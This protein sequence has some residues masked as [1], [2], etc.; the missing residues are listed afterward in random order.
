MLKR[1]FTLH[2]LLGYSQQAPSPIKESGGPSN[3][4]PKYV[5]PMNST[6]KTHTASYD[7]AYKNGLHFGGYQCI[8][9]NLGYAFPQ[10][11]D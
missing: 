2:A 3:V 7:L 11:M 9:A 5:V 1:Y 10:N 4:F 8:R 6:P